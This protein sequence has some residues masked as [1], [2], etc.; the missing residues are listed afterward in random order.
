MKTFAKNII[1]S[2][3]LLA[4]LLFKRKMRRNFPLSQL[5]NTRTYPIERVAKL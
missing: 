4:L 1:H 2:K 5:G 3:L